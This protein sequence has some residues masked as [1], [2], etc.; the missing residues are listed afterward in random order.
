MKT[1]NRVLVTGATGQ[2]GGAVARLLL[3][4][5]YQVHALTRKPDSRSAQDLRSRG[6][7]VTAGDFD[8][9][10][11]LESAMHAVDTVFAMGTPY[12]AG[13]DTETRQ[14]FALVDAARAAG[15]KYLVYT[16]V[17]SANRNTGIPHFDSKYKVE[18]HLAT[19]GIPHSVLAPVYFRENVLGPWMLPGLKEGRY[20]MALPPGRRLQQVGLGEIAGLACLMLE[21]PERFRGRR[22]DIAADDLP[23]EQVAAILTRVTGHAIRYHEVPVEQA[24]KIG[25]ED[26]VRMYEW[27]NKVGYTVEIDSLRREYPD[28]PW[29]TY[30]QWAKEQ[31][32]SVLG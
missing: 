32:W 24:R 29:K 25:G 1:S 31:D 17:A 26:F 13:V 20:A 22:I 10:D 3:N 16:S 5:G 30:E 23:G 8:R 21:H 4:R 9:L 14:G 18:Q 6:A 12:E 19:S 28:V 2:Q 27:F 15:V 7:I 11:T